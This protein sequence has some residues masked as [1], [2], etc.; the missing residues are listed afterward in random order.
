MTISSKS[1]KKEIFA[2]WEKSQEKIQAL[3]L[4][5]ELLQSKKNSQLISKENYIADFSK[6]MELHQREISFLKDDIEFLARWI[7]GNLK[8]IQK[9]ELPAFLK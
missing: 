9:V 6:R 4:E 1:L 8:K 7:S 3:K 2:E 5:I